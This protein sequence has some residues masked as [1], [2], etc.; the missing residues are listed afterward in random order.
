M[1]SAPA[2]SY[3]LVPYQSDPFPETHPDRLGSIGLIFGMKPAPIERARV[4]EIGC[5]AGNNLIPHALLHPDAHWLGVDQ[6]EAQLVPGRELIQELGLKNIE[7]RT[8]D[9]LQ[10]DPAELGT[11]DYVIAHGFLSWVAP[12]TQR[13]LFS[14]LPKLLSPEGIAYVSYNA[15]PGWYGRLAV[16]KMLH[17]HLRGVN[18]PEQR[19]AQAREFLSVLRAA[20]AV[21]PDLTAQG[22]AEQVGQMLDLPDW[23]LFHDLLEEENHPM[24]LSE[25]VEMASVNGLQY[26]GDS[27]LPKMLPYDLPTDVQRYS[28]SHGKDPAAIEQYLDFFR[29]EYFRRSLFC[30]AS[31]KLTR[32]RWYERMPHFALRSQ[33]VTEDADAASDEPAPEPGSDE[34]IARRALGLLRAAYPVP[35]PLADLAESLR[36]E[37]PESAVKDEDIVRV[38]VELGF[39]GAMHGKVS[40]HRWIPPIAETLPAMPVVT[41]LVRHQAATSNQVTSLLHL[42]LLVDEGLR[43]LL[44]LLD[45]TRG[46]EELTAELGVDASEVERALNMLLRECVLLNPEPEHR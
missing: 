15:F 32:E 25:V 35:V 27:V 41:P 31:V 23:Y 8:L 26:L 42:P 34:G 21:R 44:M 10:L 46:M 38:M 2:Q 40:L 36:R 33:L 9:I 45:G 39:R 7:L 5:S 17:E 29:G 1:K 19:V 4:L 11:F 37:L 13:R 28:R 30:H 43:A 12:P 22:L 3:D 14:L 24:L 18:R 16:R 6:S 20:L